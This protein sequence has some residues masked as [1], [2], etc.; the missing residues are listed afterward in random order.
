MW[1]IIKY[2]KLWNKVDADNRKMQ[3][4]FIVQIDGYY[5]LR[6]VLTGNALEV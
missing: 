1:Q 4:V 6:I 3:L 2:H 5:S